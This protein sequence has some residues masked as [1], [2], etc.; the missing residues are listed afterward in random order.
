MRER[1][2]PLPTLLRGAALTLYLYVLRLV[3]G[4]CFRARVM[5]LTTPLGGTSGHRNLGCETL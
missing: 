4:L 1:L 3:L 5:P 2:R